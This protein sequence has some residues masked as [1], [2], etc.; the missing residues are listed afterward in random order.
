MHI[1][2]VAEET[3]DSIFT[4]AVEAE[5]DQKTSNSHK[6]KPGNNGLISFTTMDTNKVEVEFS[7]LT[8]DGK[9]CPSTPEYFLLITQSLDNVYGELNCAGSFLI[10]P[11]DK[12]NHRG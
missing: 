7:P 1:K 10:S 11:S 8:C 5:F 4:V 2:L 3:V 9:E 12:M 6:I